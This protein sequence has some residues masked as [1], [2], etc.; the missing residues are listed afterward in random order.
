MGYQ[1]FNSGPRSFH[2]VVGCSIAIEFGN[3][4]ELFAQLPDLNARFDGD[5]F[6]NTLSIPELLARSTSL[7]RLVDRTEAIVVNLLRTG[8][9]R[10]TRSK[11]IELIYEFDKT[12]QPKMFF[13]VSATPEDPRITATGHFVPGTYATTF[14]DLKLVPS[15]LAAV[16][17]Y[18]LPIALSA[19]FL[20]SIV[21]TS[22]FKMGTAL[23]N[24]GQ[25]GGG[26][27]VQFHSGADHIPNE[28]HRLDLG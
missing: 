14:N 25:S 28:G 16:G 4:D 11:S 1:L 2:L 10:Q 21:T 7:G 15:G 12:N 23:P 3:R 18:A 24:F 26:V 17:R 8:P 22:A 27:E 20:H 9:K 19:R 6:D 5:D 13:R